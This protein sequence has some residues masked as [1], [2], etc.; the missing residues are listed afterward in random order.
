MGDNE[1][2]YHQVLKNTIMKIKIPW[3]SLKQRF[4]EKRY[5]DA[6]QIVHKI[7]SSSGSIGAKSLQDA[8]MSLQKALEEGKGRR[9]SA[10][11]QGQV[12]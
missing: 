6:A 9:N 3:T 5:A 7:K 1:E 11:L 2:L 10:A 12:F 4:R 8:A